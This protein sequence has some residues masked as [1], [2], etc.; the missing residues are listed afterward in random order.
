LAGLMGRDCAGGATVGALV[1]AAFGWSSYSEKVASGQSVNAQARREGVMVPDDQI[2]LKEYRVRPS[3]AVARAGGEPLQVIGDIK[4]IGQSRYG[5]D[6]VQSMTLIKANGEKASDTP[7]IAK[8]HNVDGAGQYRAVGVYKIPRG[9]EQGQY[10]VQ[11][12]LFLNGREV[13]R[14]DTSF[15]VAGNERQSPQAYAR[16]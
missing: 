7:Q 4:L 2:A 12:V 5:A 9:M 14:R 3:A 11:S 8:V 15:Q 16:N 6:V 10:T 1:G 13:A